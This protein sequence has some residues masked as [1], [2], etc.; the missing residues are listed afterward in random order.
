MATQTDFERPTA[1]ATTTSVAFILPKLMSGAA[2]NFDGVLMGWQDFGKDGTW[3]AQVCPSG[4][5]RFAE[6]RQLENTPP[7]SH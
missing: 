5:I 2:V 3:Q 6:C 4:R 7:Q 1:L